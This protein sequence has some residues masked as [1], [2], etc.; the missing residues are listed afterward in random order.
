VRAL[1]CHPN[2]ARCV[3]A[4]PMGARKTLMG[5]APRPRAAPNEPAHKPRAPRRPSPPQTHQRPPARQWPV[6]NIRYLFAIGA[7][8]HQG[9]SSKPPEKSTPD[10]HRTVLHA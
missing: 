5:S 4:V 10:R 6:L 1:P 8:L 7:W 2:V 3:L 9:T